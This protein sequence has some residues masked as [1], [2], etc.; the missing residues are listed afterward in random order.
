[1]RPHPIVTDFEI[2]AA[3]RYEIRLRGRVGKSTL[4]R[5]E[6]FDSEIEPAETVLRGQIVDQAALHGLLDKIE[7]LGLELLEV[8][9]VGQRRQSAR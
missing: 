1:M 8:K 3:S 5:F 7:G 2:V 6:G 4:A 9:Q